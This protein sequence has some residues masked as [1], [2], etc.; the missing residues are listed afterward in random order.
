MTTSLW[1]Q[2]ILPFGMLLGLLAVATLAGDYLLHS[3]DLVWVGRYLGIPGTLLIIGSLVYSLRKRKYITTGNPKTL[4][5]LHE[6]SAWL[7]SLM[8]LLHAGIHF[9]AIL[10]WLATVAMGVNVISGLVG[11]L[12][13]DRSRRHVQ[14]RREQFQLRG[15]SRPE[16]EQ[17]V[18]WDAV[19]LDVMTK[20]RKVHIP[21]FIGF[22]V[23]ALGHIVS[24]FLF[25]GWV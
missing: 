3:L 23:L 16:V 24:I 21:I 6:I 7:G 11:K 10:P 8:V 15:L 25:W 17:S 19:T 13:L 14:S 1:R 5:K 18:F 9:N 20:W 12:L 22:A 2:H 4:L